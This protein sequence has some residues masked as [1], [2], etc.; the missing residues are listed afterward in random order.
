M[1]TIGKSVTWLDVAAS[2]DDGGK[3]LL[4]A[5]MMNQVNELGGLVMQQANNGTSH[6]G[7][8]RTGIPTPTRR[9]LNKGVKKTKATQRAVVFESAAYEDRG[10]VDEELIAI[11]PNKEDF[12]LRQNS[13]H[14][15][16]LSKQMATDVFYCDVA[17]TP[18]GITGFSA[19]YNDK[20]ADS[21]A[22]IIDA[23]G[24]GSDNTSLWLI[25]SSEDGISLFYP[26]GNPSG[27]QTIDIGREKVFDENNDPYY[28]IVDQYKLKLGLA[29]QDWRQAARIA[30]I[31]VSDLATAGA[32]TD[33]STQL[34]L[35]A[36]EAKRKVWN[37]KGGKAGWYCNR[38]VLAALEKQAMSKSNAMVT[39]E[40]IQDGVTVTRLAGIPVNRVDAITDAETRV[41]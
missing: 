21:G 37:I 31:D 25:V 16:G 5:E 11:A 30:N 3:T 15:E 12:R 7:A 36:I 27:I 13:A 4:I 34:L 20:A 1:S 40:H 8:I 19:F 24:T 41:V 14:I 32:E 22:N 10:E 6:K 26:E 39:M 29:V 38:T 2:V 35:K 33:T 9:R 28:A 17:T 23:G 18:D